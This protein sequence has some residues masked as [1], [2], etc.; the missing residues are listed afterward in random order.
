MTYRLFLFFY[1][2]ALIEWACIDKNEQKAEA[3]EPSFSQINPSIPYIEI[4]DVLIGGSGSYYKGKKKHSNVANIKYD[5]TRN[6]LI[7]FRAKGFAKGD[8]LEL[9]WKLDGYNDWSKKVK[10][11]SEAI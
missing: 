11:E 4:D 6:L 8:T 9:S 1:L 3:S 2:I 10:Y 7:N 5:R